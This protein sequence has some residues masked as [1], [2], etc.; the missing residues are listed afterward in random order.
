MDYLPGIIA[1]TP[2]IGIGANGT[3]SP[4]GS[5][6]ATELN[7]L[8]PGLFGGS[9]AVVQ[10]SGQGRLLSAAASFQEQLQAL[11]P[12]SATSGGGQNFGTDVAS[13]AAEAQSLVDAFN[14]L[15]NIVANINVTTGLEGG[16]VLGISGLV[17]SLNSQVLANY[18]VSNS[19]LTRLSQLGITFKL[20]Q[21]TGSGSLSVDLAT[22]KSAF[23]SDPAGAFALLASAVSS[24]GDIAGS[25]VVKAGGQFSALDALSQVSNGNAYLSGFIAE[26]LLAQTQS[27]SK[28]NLQQVL[29]A[30]NEYALVSSLL[31]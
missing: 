14:S 8:S 23:E 22:L 9:S 19:G 21:L 5:L 4:S 25:F 11:K 29:L 16:S 1:N 15:Q 20:N 13:L 12:G 3:I 27:G 31:P 24:L 7:L 18:A 2:L 10:L 28:T 26:N 17:E 6:L 30:L